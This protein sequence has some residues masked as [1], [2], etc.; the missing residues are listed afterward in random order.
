MSTALRSKEVT[1]LFDAAA[2]LSTELS[3]AARS[4]LRTGMRAAH[5]H[6]GETHQG[7]LDL[8]YAERALMQH[9]RHLLAGRTDDARGQLDLAAY[10]V[11]RMSSRYLNP[12]IGYA[13]LT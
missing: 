6:A 8:V 11:E 5:D 4:Q 10:L 9:D 13:H 3:S 12:S 7:Y 2:P 1:S